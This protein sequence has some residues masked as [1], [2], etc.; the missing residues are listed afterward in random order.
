MKKIW[1]CIVFLLISVFYA[2]YAYASPDQSWAQWV[3]QLRVD[4][5]KNGIKPEVFDQVFATIPGPNSTVLKLYNTQPERRL[6]FW[7][8]GKRERI[9]R[10]SG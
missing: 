1:S 6:L 5:I 10:V 7:N 2:F 8:T 4:A 3:Q 9:K